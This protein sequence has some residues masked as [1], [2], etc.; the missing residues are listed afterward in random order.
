MKKILF[1]TLL[2]GTGFFGIS[3]GAVN[4]KTKKGNNFFERYSYKKAIEKYS[5]S[6]DGSARTIRNMAESFYRI[7]NIEKAEALYEQLVNNEEARLANDVYMYASTLMQNQKYEQAALMMKKYNELAP[8]DSRGFNYISNPNYVVELL[9]DKGQFKVRNLEINSAQ[10]DFAPMFYN[11]KVLF[12]SSREGVKPVRRKWNWNGLPFLDIYEAEKDEK[13]EL[14]NAEP[15]ERSFNKRYHEGVVCF[16]SDETMMAFTRN[17]YA[18][19]SSERIVKLNIYTCKKINDG[20]DKPQE[21]PYNNAEYSVGHPSISNDGKW[22]YFASDMPGGFGGVD[23]YKIEMLA[24]GTYGEAINLGEKINT[25]GNEMFPTIHENGMLFYSSD[26]KPGLGGL[27]V[28]V[29]QIKESGEFGKNI[30]LGVPVNSSRDDFSFILDKEMKKGYYASNRLGGKG[31]DDIY[32]FDMLKP[33]NFGKVIKGNVKDKEGNVLA[34]AKIELKDEEGNVIDT[35]LTDLNGD[36]SFDVEPD[37][38][39]NLKGAK[40]EYFDDDFAVDTHTDDDVIYAN[41]TLEKDPGISLY[42]LIL[43]KETNLPLEGVKMIVVDNMTGERVEYI[44]P[45]SGDYRRPL[46]DKRLNDRGSYNITLEKDGYFG[47]TVTYNTVFDRPGVY[48]LHENLNI[49]LDKLEVGGDVSDLIEINPIYFDFNKYNIRPDAAAELDKIVKVMTDYPGM[50]IEL[51]SHT[52][53]RGSDS[54]NRKLSDRRAKASAK[55]IR[56][57]ITNP[58][59]I[60]GKGYGEAKLINRCK[61]GVK[62]SDEEHQENRRTEFIITKLE[63]GVKVQNNSPN[64]F[65]E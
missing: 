28:F 32:Y 23:L 24:D 22:M 17:N 4:P 36:Y 27:D 10:E 5:E 8:D 1:L 12:T 3:Q 29:V 39:Y 7:G 16:N 30:N 59:R 38:N 55:Y 25:E 52:D 61:N 19:R 2:L 53:S 11:G 42:A 14:T 40:E 47:K 64:S 34:L 56:E 45:A 33:F 51:G 15:L 26:G 54:Y 13:G 37:K 60:N 50:E 35:V 41:L 63:T 44:T 62:C 58:E 49:S 46:T 57:R 6:Q 20:W 18:E 9:K 43:D 65:E 48:N 31:D 21:F